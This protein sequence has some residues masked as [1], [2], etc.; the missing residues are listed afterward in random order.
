M[1]E[2][3]AANAVLPFGDDA[4]RARTGKTWAEWFALLD[5]AG[6]EQLSH[7]EIAVYL[8]SEHGLSGWWAQSVTVGY[9][10]ARGRRDVHQTCDGYEASG[11]KTVGVAIE[12]LY[13]AWA[14][15]ALRRRW[16]AEPELTIR[17]ATPSRSLRISCLDGS[18]LDVMFYPRGEGKS[19]VSVQQSR[20]ADADGVARQKAYWKEQLARLK[21]LLEG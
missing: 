12:R 15:E 3:E 21:A 4:V 6:V 18:R 10:R 14:D 7:R 2:Q 19:Q 11:S 13:E 17:K 8:A 20:L 16:L 1:I 9:E 5:T